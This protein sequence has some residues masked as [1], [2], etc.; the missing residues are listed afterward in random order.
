M[1]QNQSNLITKKTTQVLVTTSKNTNFFQINNQ[2]RGELTKKYKKPNNHESRGELSQKQSVKRN[3]EIGEKIN[4]RKKKLY[5]KI[6]RGARA[7]FAPVL[8][9]IVLSQGKL[10][11]EI[12]GKCVVY[13]GNQSGRTTVVMIICRSQLMETFVYYQGIAR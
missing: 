11:S 10:L 12:D 3:H 5:I 2:S 7:N 9:T 1:S 6:L 13:L 4:S 8:C